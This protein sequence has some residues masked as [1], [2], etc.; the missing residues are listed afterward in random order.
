MLTYETIRRIV[1][2][3]RTTQ[4]LVG[5]P[6]DF[7]AKVTEYLKNKAKIADSKEDAW[8]LASAKR[9]LQDLLDMRE[10]KLMNLALYSI[11]SGTEPENMMQEE[12]DFFIKTVENLRNFQ[13][14]RK[15]I[16]E[17][18]EERTDN[19]AMLEDVPEFVG[20]NLKTYGPFK[21]GDITTLSEDVTKVLIEKGAAKKMQI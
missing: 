4:K 10:R 16:L 12:R 2:E 6:N 19:I 13:D 3:E 17:G 5:L 18:K 1:G 20:T 21:K 8:E 15:Q 7:F 9:A 11:R 14:S